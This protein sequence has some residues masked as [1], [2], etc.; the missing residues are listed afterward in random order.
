MAANLSAT[1]LERYRLIRALLENITVSDR[2][3]DHVVQLF[4]TELARSN[5][6]LRPD[7]VSARY[8][9]TVTN[10]YLFNLSVSDLL[11][12][13]IGLPHETYD[14]W[15]AYPYTL[16][17]TFCRLRYLA[18]E[19]SGY[20]SILT[21]T[22]FT[23]ERYMAICHP[24]RCPTQRGL[25]RPIRVILCVWVTSVAAAVPMALQ[26]GIDS[27]TWRDQVVPGTQVC[28]TTDPVL[29]GTAFQVSTWLFFVLPMSAISLL[30]CLIALA[31][32]RSTLNRGASDQS[33]DST[34]LHRSPLYVWLS[35]PAPVAVVIAFFACWAPFHAYR[36]LY[37]YVQERSALVVT[38]HNVLF[39]V[40]GV[41]YYVSA[42]I[43]PVLY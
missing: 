22:A 1:E 15:H 36:L 27:H 21:I 37:V 16:G 20:V 2:Q 41:T 32:R 34:A 31:I 4:Q 12:L 33:A 25:S 3:S 26:V 17:L 43:N 6:S 40:S 9:R 28:A 18:S 7:E 38:V 13:V 30:Y 39:Y 11:L 5:F 35:P 8:M 14:A 29:A 42:T 24:I 19:T 10:Y 23:V